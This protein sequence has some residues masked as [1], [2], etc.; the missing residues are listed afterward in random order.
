MAESGKILITGA[1]GFVGTALCRRLYQQGYALR[2][3]LRPGGS[4]LPEDL[5]CDLDDVV[6][7]DGLT[8]EHVW[9]GF[10]A[11]ITT[12]VHLAARTHCGDQATASDLYFRDN[13]DISIALARAARRSGVKKFIFLSTIK[14]NGEGVLQADHRPYRAADQPHPE[15][16]YA[17][18][19]W[20]AEQ[21]LQ[22]LFKQAGSPALT[23][24]RPP[25]IYGARAKGN[26]ALLQKWLRWGLPVPVPR[27]GNHRSLLAL[28]S[29]VEI[30]FSL[31]SEVGPGA[32]YRLLLPCDRQEWSTER[33]AEY[34]GRK[35]GRTVR[36][37]ALPGAQLRGLAAILGCEDV[38]LKFFGSLRIEPEDE[39]YNFYPRD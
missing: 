13:L 28:E 36:T 31:I 34:L 35:V 37:V 5:I 11:D 24:I 39:N 8:D 21:E 22:T 6:T 32:S 17:V 7:A 20:R 18:S 19:K 1:A 9:S 29:L 16:A 26:Y 27:A 12:V 10:L 3:L 14:V 4:S 23:I 25:L 2:V 33:L 15:G 38:C 30:I